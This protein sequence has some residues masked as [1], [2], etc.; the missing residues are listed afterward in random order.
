MSYGVEIWG[1]KSREEI[2]RVQERYLRWILG[3]SRRVA[4]YLVRGGGGLIVRRCRLEMRK[5]IK[6]GRGLVGWEA[7]RRDFFEDRGMNL[8]EVERRWENGR[9]RGEELIKVKKAKQERESNREYKYIK[10]PGLPEYL[11]KDWG[12]ERWGRIARFRLGDYLKGYR[13]W[14]EKESR[15]YNVCG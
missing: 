3:V 10:G 2:E 1:W 13:Y 15:L 7:E 4:G 9:M 5:R 8:T 11:K 6:A 12:E 14:E